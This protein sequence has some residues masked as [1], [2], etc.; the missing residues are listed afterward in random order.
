MS[1]ASLNVTLIEKQILKYH[2]NSPYLSL[3]KKNTNK[4]RILIVISYFCV[5]LQ[6]NL[7]LFFQNKKIKKD[8]YFGKSKL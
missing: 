2:A 7:L 8:G 4:T 1:N 3:K 6:I 5:V